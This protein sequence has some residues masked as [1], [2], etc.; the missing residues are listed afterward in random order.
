MDKNTGEGIKR[1]SEITRLCKEIEK[2][3]TCLSESVESVVISLE[4]I[5]RQQPPVAEGPCEKKQPPSSTPFGQLLMNY[6]NDINI[7]GLRLR[8]L[9]QRVEL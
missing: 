1:E 3:L 5:L 4:P 2:A 6:R 7:A 8:D 9:R